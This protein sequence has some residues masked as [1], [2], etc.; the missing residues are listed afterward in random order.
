[1]GASNLLNYKSEYLFCDHRSEL[2]GILVFLPQLVA[3]CCRWVRKNSLLVT[4]AKVA[5]C[6]RVA[7]QNSCHFAEITHT[8]F[9]FLRWIHDCARMILYALA[10]G[11]PNQQ[12]NQSRKSW[13]T[14]VYLYCTLW[15]QWLLLYFYT[16]QCGNI[17]KGKS[18]FIALWYMFKWIIHVHL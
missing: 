18:I 5:C 8:F 15:M 2:H 17:T 7:V 11:W 4:P 16:W 3:I 9:E 1:M 12:T 13:Q 10:V 14:W 6:Q